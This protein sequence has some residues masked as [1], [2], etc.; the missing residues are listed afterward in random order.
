MILPLNLPPVFCFKFTMDIGLDFRV[1]FQICNVVHI[2][3][4]NSFIRVFLYKSSVLISCHILLQIVII[5]KNEMQ[6]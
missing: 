1:K 2:S 5:L 3:I 4:V 6:K